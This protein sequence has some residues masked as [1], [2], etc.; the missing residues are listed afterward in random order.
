MRS[1]VCTMCYADENGKLQEQT[2]KIS[3]SRTTEKMKTANSEKNP[4]RN[5]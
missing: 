1:T 4:Q 2:H 3:S 5:L